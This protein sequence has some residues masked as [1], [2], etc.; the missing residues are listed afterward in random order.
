[1]GI[2]KS[3][4][5]YIV[6]GTGAR[7]PLD[8]VALDPPH[9]PTKQLLGNACSAGGE[10]AAA[11]GWGDAGILMVPLHANTGLLAVHVH[12]PCHCIDGKLL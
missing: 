3:Y 4:V 1:M 9:P 11:Q 6:P 5:K 12:D 8:V 10:G 7:K 2:C